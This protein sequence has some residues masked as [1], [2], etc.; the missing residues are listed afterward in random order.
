MSG[1]LTKAE[2]RDLTQRIGGLMGE[3]EDLV[4]QAWKGFADEVLGYNTWEEYVKSEIP[5]LPKFHLQERQ[6]AVKKLK[7]ATAP[8]QPGD[9][10]AM[11]AGSIAAVV[12]ASKSTVA[13]DL[14]VQN[15]TERSTT[16]AKKAAVSVSAAPEEKP[17]TVVSLAEK[18]ATKAVSARPTNHAA[19]DLGDLTNDLANATIHL[20]AHKFSELTTV[21][22]RKVRT[23]YKNL[24]AF[25]GA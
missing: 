9:R 4:V 22:K 20:K 3:L 24:V 15:R 25:M 6:A 12:G 5:D 16:P 17:A 11:G 2:A 1:K 18:R 10:E 14:S 7:K 23:A 13:N 19:C 21:D 8:E